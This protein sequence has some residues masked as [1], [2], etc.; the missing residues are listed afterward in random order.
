M[1]LRP[2]SRAA[3]VGV[4]A[5]L[6]TSCQVRTN[7]TVH[8]AD[9]GSGTVEVAVALDADAVRRLPDR[10]DDGKSTAKDLEALVRTDDLAAA[11]WRVTGPVAGDRFTWISVTKPFGTPAEATEVLAEITGPDGPLHGW[12][13]ER[14]A[15]FGRTRYRFE[16]TA[17]LSGGLEA[18]GD[19]GLS[20]AL[21]GEVLGE[22][23]ATLEKQLGKPLA[24]VFRVRISA[25]LPG[26]VSAR[27]GRSLPGDRAA[28]WTPRLG[29]PALAMNAES[30]VYDWRV[31]GLAAMA[32]LAAGACAAVLVVRLVRGRRARASCDAG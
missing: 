3:L 24:D 14:Q 4:L 15:G 16:G 22:N 32:V 27:G 29:D 19:K 28:S 26:D 8:V 18:F 10:D 9:D 12:H 30:T 5:L 31:L 2:I 11:G 1:P 13:V 21:D 25:D 6:G 7:V 20:S 23:S 17:D